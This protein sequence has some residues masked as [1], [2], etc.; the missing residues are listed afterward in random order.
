MIFKAHA[1]GKSNEPSV[2]VSFT[3]VTSKWLKPQTP[4]PYLQPT[5]LSHCFPTAKQLIDHQC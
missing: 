3:A 4:H 1:R 2:A 5:P